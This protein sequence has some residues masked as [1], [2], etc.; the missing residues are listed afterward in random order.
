M[1][2]QKRTHVYI[3]ILYG[4]IGWGI[5]LVIVTVFCSIEFLQLNLFAMVLMK[6]AQRA[7]AGSMTTFMASL[8]S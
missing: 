2:Y 5:P 7:I 1:R 4:L 3:F 8:H 6:M